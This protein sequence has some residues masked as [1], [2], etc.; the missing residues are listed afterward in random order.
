MRK[1]ILFLLLALLPSPFL[2]AQGA[3]AGK[4]TGV[5]SDQSGAVI[6]GAE[7][8]ALSKTAYALVDEYKTELAE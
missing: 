3:V 5:I 7:M 8:Q 2:L 1:C 4:I 6:P